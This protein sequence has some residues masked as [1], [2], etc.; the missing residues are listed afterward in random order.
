MLCRLILM[1]RVPLWINLCTLYF[2]NVNVAMQFPQSRV[3]LYVTLNKGPS[4]YSYHLQFWGY[5]WGV[6]IKLAKLKLK[7][8][9]N[10]LKCF[11][12][13]FKS[14][15]GN[16]TYFYFYRKKS[17]CVKVT[18]NQQS[19]QKGEMFECESL[20]EFSKRILN[21]KP[22]KG[23]LKL[24]NQQ[25]VTKSLHPLYIITTPTVVRAITRVFSPTPSMS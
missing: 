9:C 6:L 7:S 20:F 14:V 5:F 19:V 21:V 1:H 22:I 18:E 17:C 23:S 2:E 24:C 11:F 3:K 16:F 25:L 12:W 10:W 4:P 13:I 15:S 8:N